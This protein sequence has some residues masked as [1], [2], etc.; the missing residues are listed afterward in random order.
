M[1]SINVVYPYNLKVSGVYKITSPNG[2]VYVGQSSNVIGRI[3]SHK[4]DCKLGKNFA[5]YNS[6]R[7][8]GIENHKL[9]LLYI[10]E[11]KFDRT[12]MEQFFINFYDSKKNGLNMIYA[13]DI[14]NGFK[15]KKH[16]KKEI[17]KIK[18]RMK[19]FKPV[20]AIDKIKKPVYC[21]HNDTFYE[22]FTK[23]AKDLG[24]SQSLI[25]QMVSGARFNKFKLVAK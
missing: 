8:Y 4:R 15:G 1:S 14:G 7:K 10:S 16:S 22:S 11:D 3:Y 19:G 13:D 5:I 23:C 17:E 25:S 18:N 9:D 21:G 12:R 24:V 6:F 20:E 2:K